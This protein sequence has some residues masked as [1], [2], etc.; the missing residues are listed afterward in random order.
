MTA[1]SIVLS[2]AAFVCLG[3]GFLTTPIPVV[4]TVFSFAAPALALAGIAVGGVALSR[5]KRA[6]QPG[7]GAV[8]GI[9]LNVVAFLPALLVAMTCGVCN[10]LFSAGG[11]QVRR[12]FDLRMGPGGV[13]V[14]PDG[15][16]APGLQRPPPFP[17]PAPP[18][19]APMP[20][21][22]LPPQSPGAQAPPRIPDAPAPDAPDAPSAP[23]PRRATP[24]PAFPPPPMAPPRSP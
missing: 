24:P 16:V 6:G 10:A 14:A 21:G 23:A 22:N 4:G 19:I 1:A 11:V 12:D 17:A 13:L 15:G 8:V 5:A 2:V 7:D 18:P 20:P 9:V 3:I